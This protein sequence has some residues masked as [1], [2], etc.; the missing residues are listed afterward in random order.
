M[1]LEDLY[2]KILAQAMQVIRAQTYLPALVNH[3]TVGDRQTE[4]TRG[5]QTEVIVPPEFATRDVVPASTPPV[6]QGDPNPNTVPVPLNY[7]KEVNFPLTDKHVALLENADREVPMFLMNAVGPIVEDMTASIAANYKGIY[8]YVG[9][10]GTTPFAAAPTDAQAAKKVMTKQK[11][12]RWMRQMVLNTDAYANAIALPQ[13]TQAFNFGSTEAIREGEVSRAI[14]FDW[15]E[16]VGMD[17]ITHENPNGTPAGWLVNQAD[18]AIGDTTVTIDTGAN[19]PVVGDIF[20]VAGDTQT[21]VVKGY[22]A[23]VITYAPKA[24]VAWAD[25]AAITFKAAHAIN[26]AFNPF[27]FAFDSRPATRLRLQGITQNFMTWVDDMTGVTLRLEI[28]DEYHQTGFY[29]S[30]LWGTVLVDERLACRVA[31]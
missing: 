23:N 3:M 9:T 2:G 8:G 14:G 6:S 20:T 28:R 17:D 15:H 27:A 25:N 12:P 22:A 7:W 26:L 21:Y 5:G 16:D 10:A 24:K 1:A 13:F 30:C 29:L 4:M 31:G 18:H 19:A 11:C